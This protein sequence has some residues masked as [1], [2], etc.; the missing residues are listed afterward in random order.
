MLPAL[1]DRAGDVLALA[2]AFLARFAREY[3]LPVPGLTPAAEHQL[4]AH[5]WP[6]NVR[7]LRN[8]LERAILLGRP[9]VPLD[10]A[11]LALDAA[12]VRLKTGENGIPFPATMSEIIRGAAGSMVRLSGGNKSE[13][14]RRLRISRTRLLRL[15]APRG[16]RT[17]T[18][19]EEG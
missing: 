1:R 8:V 3:R 7:E 17:D 4:T 18:L 6:G 11:D 5:L 15:L 16:R 12:S 19:E 2:Q 9:G 14:A 13:A 10:V